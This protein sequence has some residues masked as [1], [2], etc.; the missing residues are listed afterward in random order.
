MHVRKLYELD[1]EKFIDGMYSSD[2]LSIADLSELVSIMN[3]NK[4][5]TLDSQAPPKQKQLPV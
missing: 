1:Y 4:Q 3:N 5:N 2:L